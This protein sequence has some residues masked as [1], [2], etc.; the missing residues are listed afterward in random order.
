VRST[1]GDAVEQGEPIRTAL[2][3]YGLA[4]AAFHG[5][6]LATTAGLRLEVVVTRDAT[7]AAQARADH[8][9]VA[10]VADVAD[11]VARA[12]DLDLA[13]VATPNAT[14]VAVARALLDA[15]LAVVVDKPVAPTA[16]E[17]RDL[18]A[19]ARA[20]GLALV[21][22]HNRRWDGDLLTIRRLLIEGRLGEVLRFESRFERWRPTPPTGAAAGWKGAPDAAAGILADLGV[23]LVDQA[24]ALFGPPSTVYAELDVRHAGGHVDD[25]AFVALTWPGGRRAH[26]WASAMAAVAG[27]RFRVLGSTA[28]Y[29]KHGMDVQEAALRAGDRPG[30]GW[31][32][33]DAAAWGVLGVDGALEP[34]AT[35]PGDYPAFAVG[36]VAHLRGGAPPPVTW[37][38]AVAGL[39][40]LDAARRSAATGGPVAVVAAG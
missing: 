15:G 33:E 19:L 13:V 40:V 23:H 38:D 26:L 20:R 16:A 8:P 17:A 22:F 2:V 18:G 31:G 36:L 29:V 7:R 34:V 10:V 3:G 28:A 30:P 1:W 4:G 24:I 39:E 11:V 12:G 14:H 32:V 35:E 25:D 9:G 5:P 21:P 6:L 37:A 27:P